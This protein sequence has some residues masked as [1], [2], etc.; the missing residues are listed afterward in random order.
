MAR[1]TYL[2]IWPV[3]P[4]LGRSQP[5][6]VGL[7]WVLT[8]LEQIPDGK[9]RAI[10]AA[11]E[12]ELVRRCGFRARAGANWVCQP[13][14]HRLVADNPLLRHLSDRPDLLPS[15]RRPSRWARGWLPFYDIESKMSCTVRDA[16]GLC[17]TRRKLQQRN[18]RLGAPF[19]NYVVD[20]LEPDGF[21]PVQR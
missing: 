14:P 11:D 20:R 1:L 5:D 8:R 13:L 16:P 19:F 15:G 2:G 7:V 21:Y 4:T 9:G 3:P 6:Y 17:M 12:A 18:W 10:L